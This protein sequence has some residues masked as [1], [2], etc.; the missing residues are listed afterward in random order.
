MKYLST[1][2][3]NFAK[4]TFLLLFLLACSPERDNPYDP[5]SNFYNNKTQISGIC[6]NRVQVPINNAKINLL[7]LKSETPSL[8]TST[9]DNGS[10]ELTD[11][12]AESVLVIAEK[13][14]FVSE[15]AYL[16]LNVYKSETLN[17]ILEG[18]P[19]FIS[20]QV[21]SYCIRRYTPQDSTVLSIKCNISDDEG[22]SDITSVFATIE[23]LPDSLPLF[24]TAGNSYE[25]S[26][27]EESL[28]DNLDNIVGRN[29][30]IIA[31]DHTSKAVSSPLQLVRIIRDTLEIIS[32][33]GGEIVSS[34]PVLEW[35]A[36]NF[37]FSHSFFCEIWYLPHNLQPQLYYRYDNI[38]ANTT[39]LT[40]PDTNALISG[41]YY[42]QI[43][44]KDDYNNW[45]KSTEAAFEV[46]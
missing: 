21:N 32:P 38:P 39:S 34:R 36:P 35:G 31:C 8:Q 11:C 30:Y 5:N 12:P 16:S 17:F 33:S 43:G 13:D 14:G 6:K 19:K 41:Q 23:S 20:T 25:N 42:W 15:S 1:L 22:Q 27:R 37:L 29:I 46:Q 7:P 44:V 18:L 10:Y 28:S 40:I 9:N 4:F 24:F 3:G 26:F 45:A 2:Q